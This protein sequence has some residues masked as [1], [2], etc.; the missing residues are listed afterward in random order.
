MQFILCLLL[1][2]IYLQAKPLELELSARSAILMNADSGAVL[3]EKHAH[4]PGYPASITKIATALFILDHKRPELQQMVTVSGDALKIKP[5]KKGEHPPYWDEVDGTKMG[6]LKGEI[7]SFE[8]LLHGLMM[9]SGNDAAN[10]MAATLSPSIPDFIEEMNQ[11]V[12]NLGCKNTQFMNPHG[13]HHPEHYT[14]AYDICLITKKALQI[15]KFREIVSK[16]SYLCPK[17]NKRGAQELRQKNALLKPGVHYY[18]KAI[19]VKTGFHSNAQNTL[20]AAAE[21]EGRTLIAVVLG[22]QDRKK[23]YEDV[24]ELFDAAFAEQKR[25]HTFFEANSIFTREIEGA[26]RPLIA[27]LSSDLKLSYYPAEETAYKAFIQ[28]A[29][30]PL[31]IAKGQIVGEVRIQDEQGRILASE[32]LFSREE[33][34][35]KFFYSLKERILGLF[36]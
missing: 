33:V 12:R 9:V 30:L 17:S 31:P 25:E 16:M 15:P 24:I 29:S 20:V 32:S 3:Y 11:Y 35:E 28:W 19:G 1:F 22:C 6:I 5:L 2:S 26:K 18:P 23:R 8:S 7:L 13:L 21:H 34:R 27:S 14:T 4:I 10:A 36:R